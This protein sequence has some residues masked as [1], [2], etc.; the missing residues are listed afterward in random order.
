MRKKK[1]LPNMGLPN[2]LFVKIKP[3]PRTEWKKKSIISY[4]FFSSSFGK[5]IVASMPE[6]ICYTGLALSREEALNELRSR[7]SK[8]I[9]RSH[10]NKQHEHV[11]KLFAG[12]WEKGEKLV[13]YLKGTAFQ[14]KVWEALLKIPTGKL[15]TYSKIA[16]TIGFS[17]AQ[18]AVG[19]AIGRN[20]VLYIIPCHRVI[21]QN[22]KMGGFYWGVEKKIE[23][24][25]VENAGYLHFISSV[26]P[27]IS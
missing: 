18:R 11:K 24:L 22:G 6:G 5:I 27:S 4:S 15:S 2:K 26:T 16:K 3:I 7:F 19:T 17:Q 13:L 25:N 23:I 12:H 14:L 9:F 20:P 8:G 1:E 10:K 21:A